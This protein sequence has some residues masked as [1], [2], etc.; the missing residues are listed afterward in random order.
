M[1]ELPYVARKDVGDADT[2]HWGSGA[3]IPVGLVREY[4]A[5]PAPP[6]NRKQ[7]P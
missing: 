7:K 5:R 6:K 3:C 1:R 2:G 4:E